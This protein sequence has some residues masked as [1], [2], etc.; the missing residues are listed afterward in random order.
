MRITPIIIAYCAFSVALAITRNSDFVYKMLE[1]MAWFL[2]WILWLIGPAGSLLTWGPPA[3]VLY[4]FETALCAWLLY[5]A[6]RP[7]KNRRGAQ[8]ALCIVWILSGLL[9][10]LD[11]LY[12]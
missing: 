7:N 12:G 2:V 3:F 1:P 10:F 11:G 6:A 4:S 9:P 8:V 5:Y